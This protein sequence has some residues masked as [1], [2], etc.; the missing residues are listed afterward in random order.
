MADVDILQALVLTV[1]KNLTERLEL[2]H[3]QTLKTNGRMTDAEEDIAALQADADA[4]A[5]VAAALVLHDAKRRE[6][7]DRRAARWRWLVP[8]VLSVVAIVSPIWLPYITS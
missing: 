1:E 4:T 6:A 7:G 2:I 8:T 5:K 3:E